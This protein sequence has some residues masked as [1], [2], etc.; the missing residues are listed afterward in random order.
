MEQAGLDVMDFDKWG[1]YRIRLTK[2]DVKDN[3]EILMKL[4][5][6]SHGEATGPFGR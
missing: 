4:L 3:S 5:E 6:S 2:G 1:R